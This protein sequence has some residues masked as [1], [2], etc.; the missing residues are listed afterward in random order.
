MANLNAEDLLEKYI[1]NKVTQ[2][3]RLLVENWFLQKESPGLPSAEQILNDH[4]TIKNE[5]LKHIGG[6]SEKKVNLWPGIAAAA[7]II[8]VIGATLFFYNHDAKSIRHPDKSRELAGA[9]NNIRP[10][11]NIAVLTLAHGKTIHLSDAKTGIVIKNTNLTYN[12]GT[13]INELDQANGQVQTITTPRGG[14]Y[15]ITLSDG[16]KVWLNSA[17]SLTY[18]GVLNEYGQRKVDLKGEAYFEVARDKKHPFIVKSAGQEVEVLGTHFNISS[19]A[20]EQ[21]TTTT[22]LEGKVHVI[23]LQLRNGLKAQVNLAPGQQSILNSAGLN[24]QNIKTEEATAW[25]DG[26]FLFENEN[27]ESIMRK[28]ARWYDVEVEYRGK[29]TDKLF[30]GMVSRSKNITQVLKIIQKTGNV[31]I[32]IEGRRVIIML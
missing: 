12:D 7:A 22:L 3:E 25:K 15:Q 9:G 10:G 18:N 27:L 26:Y 31:K 30:G 13:A 23:A 1:A 28:I 16:T 17:S 11:K 6:R 19:Y 20:D 5:I 29:M 14:T 24:K 32:K 21:Q 8:L 4:F 2:E